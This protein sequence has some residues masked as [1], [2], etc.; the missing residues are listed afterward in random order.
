VSELELQL[1]VLTD[2]G[3]TRGEA[4]EAIHTGAGRPTPQMMQAKREELQQR[5]DEQALLTYEASRA[6]KVEAAEAALQAKAERQRLAE[7]ARELVRDHFGDATD[8]LTD[9]E[10]L[11]AAGIEESASARHARELDERAAR[12]FEGSGMPLDIEP[13]STDARLSDV[14]SES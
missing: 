8:R 1:A 4:F 5:A 9:E 10:A 2:A 12:K 6:G 11:I 13:I 7:G 3:M 14:W